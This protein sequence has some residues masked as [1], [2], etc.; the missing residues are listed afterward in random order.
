[1]NFVNW[2]EDFQIPYAYG[3]GC[4][5]RATRQKY[6][7]ARPDGIVKHKHNYL[8]FY[9]NG[10]CD[11]SEKVWIRFKRHERYWRKFATFYNG[12]RS[13]VEESQDGLTKYFLL[14]PRD[15]VASFRI[16]KEKN[17]MPRSPYD[18]VRID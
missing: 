13:E 11:E 8:V 18:N 6:R 9:L 12:E 17:L 15:K 16:V 7:F 10:D 14:T 2:T 5:V 1:M 3:R 4:T